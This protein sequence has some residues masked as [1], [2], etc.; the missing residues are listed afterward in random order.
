M[1]HI[2]AITE[3]VILLA[4]FSLIISRFVISFIRYIPDVKELNLPNLRGSSFKGPQE[5]SSS[6]KGS[7]WV[8]WVE[9]RLQ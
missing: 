7:F 2:H 6:L 3:E 1:L 5:P 8:V 9:T 4:D